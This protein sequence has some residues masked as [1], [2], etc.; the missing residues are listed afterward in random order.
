MKTKIYS[1][2]E[3]NM[4]SLHSKCRSWCLSIGRLYQVVRLWTL[5]AVIYSFSMTSIVQARGADQLL[6]SAPSAHTVILA[7]QPAGPL[8][9]V[10]TLVDDGRS[11]FGS[12]MATGDFNGDG[13]TDIALTSDIPINTP[14]HLTV[15]ELTTQDALFAEVHIR[16]GLENLLPQVFFK[17]GL[18]GIRFPERLFG[19]ALA[20]ADF[21]GDGFDDLA[22]GTTAGSSV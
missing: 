8:V 14:G 3:R 6:L 16:I 4:T 1:T 21:N 22:I 11:T 9:G 12:T 7:E 15:G 2:V 20:A 5:I 18:P 19:F 13:E 10:D 17:G